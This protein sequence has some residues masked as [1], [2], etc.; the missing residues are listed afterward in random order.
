MA[1]LIDDLEKKRQEDAEAHGRNFIKEEDGFQEAWYKT[2]K[3]MTLE[4][5]PEFI[6]MLSQD[7]QHDYGTICHAITAGAIG[8]AWAVERGPSGGITGFQASCIMWEFIKQ[9]MHYDGPMRLLQIK[10]MLYPQ[11]E[12]KFNQLSK[13]TAK[14]LKEE[15]QKEL[16]K[17]HS[18]HPRVKAHMEQ[19]AE[20]MIPFGYTV[21]EDTDAQQKEAE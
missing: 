3:E 8:A 11:S 2:A 21:E 13:E 14:W 7:Y 5:L 12:D 17:G 20:G 19:V 15:A 10:D 1:E 18:M 4:K 16:A 9:W 6:R